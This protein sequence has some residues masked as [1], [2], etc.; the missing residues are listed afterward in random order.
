V[1]TAPAGWLQ[2][3]RHDG[4]S[5][6]PPA[7]ADAGEVRLRTM[8]RPMRRAA[9]LL[10]RLVADLGG[11]TQQVAVTSRR[12]LVT[13]EGEHAC[14]AHL[15]A[16]RD[17]APIECT[18]GVVYGDDWYREI[19][20]LARQ[21]SSFALLRE[22]AE[23]FVELSSLGLG[24]PRRRRFEYQP[25]SGWRG[26]VR[27][28]LTEWFRPGFPGRVG[29]IAVPPA[30]RLT[31]QRREEIVQSVLLEDQSFGFVREHTSIEEL[32]T[33][34]GLTGQITTLTGRS[35]SGEPRVVDH[36]F[37]TDRTY[38]YAVRLES[39]PDTLDDNRQVWRAVVDSVQSLPSPA[40]NAAEQGALFTSWVD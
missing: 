3:Y 24:H 1:A 33:A 7:G 39:A 15:A 13:E 16:T 17:G 22:T 8:C 38:G 32:V 2:V 37:L 23:T 40:T 12:R 20:A 35:M 25:P 21:A 30:R 34:R 31:T 18:L 26:L 10:D 28:L 11:P 6:F 14:V 5:L 29:V 19:V 4:T 36:A 27:H 9:D